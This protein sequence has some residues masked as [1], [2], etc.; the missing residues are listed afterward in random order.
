M[1]RRRHSGVDAKRQT[2]HIAYRPL[3]PTS[4][5]HSVFW[6]RG[7]AALHTHFWEV[8]NGWIAGKLQYQVACKCLGTL[9]KAALAAL[10]S[11]VGWRP[12][13]STHKCPLCGSNQPSEGYRSSHLSLSLALP[14]LPRLENLI[15]GTHIKTVTGNLLCTSSIATH[16][17]ALTK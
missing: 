17:Q 13:A 16:R 4:H 5:I 7:H 1:T 11:T 2:L 6:N 14:L 8:V 9:P 3:C 12:V 10:S 15:C